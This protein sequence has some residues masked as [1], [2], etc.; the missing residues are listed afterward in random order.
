[1]LATYR[2]P[3]DTS[4]ERLIKT[5]EKRWGKETRFLEAYSRVTKPLSKE[6]YIKMIGPF[7]TRV[8]YASDMKCDECEQNIVDASNR[9]IGC[10][11]PCGITDFDTIFLE[12]HICNKESA[13]IVIELN[14]TL[15]QC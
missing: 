14:F 10:L 2:C 4:D 3:I 7:T 11:F 9:S 15:Y 6:G 1:M 5:I 12:T 13:E 8:V